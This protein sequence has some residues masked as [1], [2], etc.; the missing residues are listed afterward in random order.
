MIKKCYQYYKNLVKNIID[1]H[2]SSLRNDRSIASYI[3]NRCYHEIQR[4]HF[5]SIA[6]YQIQFDFSNT[7]TNNSAIF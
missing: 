1:L 4:K 3:G 7:M 2:I 6:P 5:L